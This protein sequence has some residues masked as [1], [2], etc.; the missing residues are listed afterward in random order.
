[1]KRLTAIARW[2]RRFAEES[3]TPLEIY[4]LTSSEAAGLL[5]AEQFPVFKLPSRTVIEES[6]ILIQDFALLAQ[7]WTR[8]TL[9]LLK[10]DMLVVDT[11]P[12]GYYDELPSALPLCRLKV[13]IH[14][15]V[16]F[17]NLNKEDFYHALSLYDS[18]IIPETK[19]TSSVDL[20][21]QL[22]DRTKYFGPVLARERDE[23]L[24]REAV[25]RKLDIG[26]EKV[27]VYLTAG[28]GG[29]K[30]TE[31]QIHKLYEALR[32]LEH[33]HFVIGAGFLFR[34]ARLYAADVTWL[35][36]ENALEL[37]PGFDLAISAAGYNTFHELMY[38]G[39]PSIFLP[40]NKWADNQRARAEKAVG[41][42]AAIVFEEMPENIIFQQAVKH[43]F[44]GKA[45][46][47]ASQNALSLVPH[48]YARDIA[49]HLLQKL[50][51]KL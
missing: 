2:L 41:A 24:S 17:T 45:R 25:R 46:E 8:Q 48:N 19:E 43:W 13:I 47:K 39:V 51:V 37:M 9:E 4:F 7:E 34:G 6:G 23:L 16:E 20:P 50:S 49:L 40:Q 10:P 35:V 5:F 27:V 33:V 44:D 14:R 31:K 29:D 28:G 32:E 26:G 12:A 36:N 22:M 11:F 18:I 1:M 3:A 30:N 15:S 38:A 21:S 42:G